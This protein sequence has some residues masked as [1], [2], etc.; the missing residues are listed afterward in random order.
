M[1][2]NYIDKLGNFSY[3]QKLKEVSTSMTAS[4]ERLKGIL[5]EEGVE[6]MELWISTENELY[7]KWLQ[8]PVQL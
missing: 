3:I 8:F 2:F 4:K 6:Q 5:Q 1:S 7:R